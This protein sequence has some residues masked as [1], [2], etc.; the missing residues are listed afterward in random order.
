MLLVKAW[1]LVMEICFVDLSLESRFQLAAL[2]VGLVESA[3]LVP[4]FVVKAL[5][6]H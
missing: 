5:L 6:L 1:V 3:D 4:T 2:Q